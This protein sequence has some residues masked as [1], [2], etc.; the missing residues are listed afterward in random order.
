M[1][2]DPDLK[3][4]PPQTKYI[5]GNEAC[6]RF[7][8]YGV[9]AILNGYATNLFG[10]GPTG[11]T[12]A[13]E[14]IH[15][16]TM[17]CY[18]L[19]LLGAWLADRFWGRYRT[20]LFLSLA[21]CVGH[22]ILAIGEGT[23]AGLF[24][25]LAFLAVGTGGIKPCVSAFA[26]DQFIGGREAL[27]P[28]IYNWFYWSINFGAFFA[29]QYLPGVAKTSYAWAFGLPGIAMGL[30]TLIFWLGR[31]TYIRVPPS[32]QEAP[33][34]SEQ[35]AADRRMLWKI[36]ALFSMVPFFWCLF[37]QQ[38]ST[39]VN[40]GDKMIPTS[41]LFLDFNGQTMRS[42]NAVLILVFVPLFAVVLYPLLRKLGIAIT[43]LRC[44]TAG[45]FLAGT[46]FVASAII[47]SRLDAGVPMNIAWQ[48]WQYVLL[49]AGEVMISTTGLAFAF[50]QA[51]ARLKS[52]IMS[53][54]L[55]T[56]A[57]GNGVTALVTWINSSFV[58]AP[59]L[60]ELYFYAALVA[61]AGV[62]FALIARRFP[63]NEPAAA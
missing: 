15:I 21:Y 35:R 4:M 43:P 33:R 42:A 6:E 26:G 27:L 44:M 57:V 50:T 8:Y 2:Q 23:K 30:A 32:Q 51:P 63:V 41:F 54:W 24:I 36:V 38:H 16:F 1:S 60:T 20:I 39:W 13:K 22:G 25:G 11:A 48:F 19:P 31:R 49:T 47:Q 5:V 52:T 46:S 3:R 29:F 7:S 17:V 12:Y 61:A 18:V 53:F 9:M 56:V 59:I 37:D 55:L 40:Q 62:I 58:K 10:G 14:T 45:F 34:T 28:R